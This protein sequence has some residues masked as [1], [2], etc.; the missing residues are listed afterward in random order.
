MK[1]NKSKNI[2]IGILILIIIVLVIFIGLL[3]TGTIENSFF[4][5]KVDV[6][7]G[8]NNNDD[9]FKVELIDKIV[10]SWNLSSAE[11]DGEWY[12]HR[13]IF[14]SCIEYGNKL[15]INSDYT[16]SLSIGC[17]VDEDGTF[18]INGNNMVFTN[19]DG[20]I[21]NASY[22]EDGADV[23]IRYHYPTED[24]ENMYLL[25]GQ[26]DNDITNAEAM[27]ISKDSTEFLLGYLHD[28]IPYC[29]DAKN[30]LIEFE[31][32]LSYRESTQFSKTAELKSYLLIKLSDD[33]VN[34]DKYKKEIYVEKDNKLYCLVPDKGCGTNFDFESASYEITNYSDDSINVLAEVPYVT[35]CDDT[36]LIMKM[37][38]IIEKHANNNWVVSE[39]EEIE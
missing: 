2:I 30:E 13:E 4:N 17:T 15:T 32:G 26:E 10:G 35:G 39:Y 22:T 34:F 21:Y 7:E 20:D 38:L 18:T 23:V 37:K 27:E 6:S 9:D 36:K 5:S 29:G 12:N 14:G 25:F 33:I 11:L 19:S 3:V 1:N 8:N 31:G 28:L 16:Y 24:M